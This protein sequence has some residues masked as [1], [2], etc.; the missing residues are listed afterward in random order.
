MTIHH[1]WY[2][3]HK[4]N[5]EGPFP[6]GQIKQELLLGRYKAD[7]EVSHDKETWQKLRT[8]RSLI[9]EVL[10]TARD[11]PDREERIEA[12]RRWAD[13]RRVE[14]RGEAREV[15]AGEERREGEPYESTEYRLK[16][17]TSLREAKRRR[18]NQWSALLSVLLLIGVI[19]YVAVRWAPAP[20]NALADCTAKA[21]P[22]VNWSHCRMSGMQ[23]PNQNL[24]AAIMESTD[25]SGAN[26]YAANLRKARLS[27][28]D[29]GGAHL[30]LAEF[31]QASLKGASL[32]S[33]DV[34]QAS[35]VEA[36]LS[37]ADLTGASITDTN[38]SRAILDH[39]LWVDG[40]K[41]QPG[42]VGVCR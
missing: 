20:E 7:D 23:Q 39:A 27:Y 32:R 15:V 18:N 36:D 28:A 34:S 14:R 40:R 29:L 24:E 31:T 9:P 35:F 13:E 26:F 21:G 38:F 1:A 12:A 8:V 30:R 5:V 17:E 2:I 19:I 33:A 6:A 11:D 37:Y 42:S 3:R 25:L 22:G 4:G 10:L 41:C 16:R